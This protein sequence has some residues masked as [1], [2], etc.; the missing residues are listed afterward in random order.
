[1]KKVKEQSYGF[2][3]FKFLYLKVLTKENELITGGSLYLFGKKCFTIAISN[4]LWTDENG[5]PYNFKI[6][7]NVLYARYVS[8]GFD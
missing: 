2:H 1:M 6:I 5:K 7:D 4:G 8:I 3:H